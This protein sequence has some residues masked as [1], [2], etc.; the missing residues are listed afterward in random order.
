MANA[1]RIGVMLTRDAQ[2]IFGGPCGLAP[3][4]NDGEYFKCES[5][6]QDGYFLRLEVLPVERNKVVA[7]RPLPVLN[8]SIP[9]NYVLYMLS[10][11]DD[12]TLI[13]FMHV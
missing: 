8:L 1:Q 12:E 3:Y 9:V 6:E 7:G 11:P 4:L 5:A 13:G 2:Q 10:A